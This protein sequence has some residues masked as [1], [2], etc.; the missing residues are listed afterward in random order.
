MVTDSERKAADERGMASDHCDQ[1][2]VAACPDWCTQHSQPRDAQHSGVGRSDLLSCKLAPRTP[3]TQH[4]NI[5][6]LSEQVI[7][8]N[9]V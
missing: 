9:T 2:P 4:H 8:N 3:T 1:G 5:S 6:E 7:S